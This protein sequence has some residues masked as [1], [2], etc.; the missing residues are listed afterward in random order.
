MN[1]GELGKTVAKFAP[2]LGSVL[3]I[4]GGAVLGQAIAGVFGGDLK[5]T[6]DLIEKINND[7]EAELKLLD[8]QSRERLEIERL[9]VERIRFANEDRASARNKELE[10]IRL[11]G[12]EDKTLKVLAYTVTLGFFVSIYLVFSQSSN[13]NESEK[14]MLSILLGML[15]GK[16]QTIIDYFFGASSVRQNQQ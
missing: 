13:L 12:K 3:P 11:T 8:I 4:P 10:H 15:A 5:N 2:L 6:D 16:F 1:L 9:A 14:Q 7:P